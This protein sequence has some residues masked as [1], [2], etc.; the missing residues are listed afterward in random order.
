MFNNDV[1]CWL[2][3]TKAAIST[4][5]SRGWCLPQQCFVYR[6][7]DWPPTPVKRH[8][9]VIMSPTKPSGQV[10]C[11]IDNHL[12][13]CYRYRLGFLKTPPRRHDAF[14]G[15]YVFGKSEGDE[16]RNAFTSVNKCKD[17]RKTSKI[18]VTYRWRVTL[19][20]NKQKRHVCAI[21]HD[22]LPCK[23]SIS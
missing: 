19:N 12:L 11:V 21:S 1:R 23:E 4:L 2:S 18:F 10:V 16:K 20:R 17:R 13:Q 14:Y 9:P 5:Q 3:A 6:G 7:H 15:L 22:G 8:L